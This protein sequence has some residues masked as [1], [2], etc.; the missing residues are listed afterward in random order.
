MN[1]NTIIVILGP[2]GH[3]FVAHVGQNT[4]LTPVLDSAKVMTEADAQAVLSQIS[5]PRAVRR[6]RDEYRCEIL[7]R[8][9]QV[10]ELRRHLPVAAFA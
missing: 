10:E 3:E 6:D 7:G 5:L 4:T 8:Q 2:S 9:R 1:R